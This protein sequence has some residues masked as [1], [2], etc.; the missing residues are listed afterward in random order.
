MQ[1]VLKGVFATKIN[2]FLLICYP[3][4]I[5]C[6]KTVFFRQK[7]DFR[8]EKPC[9]CHM[10]AGFTMKNEECR[11]HHENEVRERSGNEIRS[12]ASDFRN[13]ASAARDAAFEHR[14]LATP[15]NVKIIV[16]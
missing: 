2:K 6:R 9:F 13:A 4:L 1:N 7:H 11:R 14:N 5:F 16:M 3:P 15:R 10:D 8:A 12:G